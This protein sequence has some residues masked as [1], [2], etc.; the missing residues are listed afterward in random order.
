MFAV[1]ACTLVHWDR[2]CAMTATSLHGDYATTSRALD[3]ARLRS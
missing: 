2:C 3:L 1:A